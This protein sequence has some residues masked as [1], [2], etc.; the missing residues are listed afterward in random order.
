MLSSQCPFV[1]LVARVFHFIFL[2][3]WLTFLFLRHDLDIVRA[4]LDLTW[5]PGGPLP[6]V[7][8]STD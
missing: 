4:G 8:L 3:D 2:V 5:G 6:W 7:V 1:H